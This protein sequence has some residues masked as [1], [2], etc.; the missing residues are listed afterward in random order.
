MYF[1]EFIHR[2]QANGWKVA[3]VTP[4][5]VA[6]QC[7]H[8]GCR[9]HLVVPMSELRDPGPCPFQHASGYAAPV[10]TAYEALISELV[11]RRKALG[12]A[13]E[14]VCAAAGLAPGHIS[15]LEAFARVATFPTLQHWTATLGLEVTVQPARLPRATIAAIDARKAPLREGTKQRKNA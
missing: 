13:Q 7:G 4:G 14:E 8:V 1:H 11:E 15:K 9:G 12:L 5:A 2:A 10:F 6:L 3:R